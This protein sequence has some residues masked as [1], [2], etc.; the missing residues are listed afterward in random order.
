MSSTSCVADTASRR[1]TWAMVIRRYRASSARLQW[2]TYQRSSASRSLNFCVWRPFTTAHPVKPGRMSWRR[3]SSAWVDTG[4]V[5]HQERPRSHQAHVAAE[6]IPELRELVDARGPQNAPDTSQPLLIRGYLSS[7]A[8]GARIVRNFNITN[9]RPCQPGR[10]WRKRMGRPWETKIAT[11]TEAKTGRHDRPDDRAGYVRDALQPH[12][13]ST[14]HHVCSISAASVSVIASEPSTACSSR[15]RR[16]SLILR[17]SAGGC[18][19]LTRNE[20]PYAADRHLRCRWVCPRDRLA[21]RGVSTSRAR[22]TNSSVSSTMS[23]RCT[24][25]S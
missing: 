21:D 9:G 7:P 16:T 19:A 11:A 2:S 15:H 14:A 6:H 4:Q 8:N 23:L 24:V 20:R 22:R 17:A 10:S 3:D 1:T 13:R 5:L 18:P 12:S 25:L